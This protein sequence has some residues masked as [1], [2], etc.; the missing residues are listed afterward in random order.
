MIQEAIEGDHYQSI[1]TNGE[2]LFKDKGS[3]FFAFARCVKSLDEFQSFLEDLKSQYHDARHFCYAYRFQPKK[4]EVRINDDGEPAHSAG[5]PIFNAI[6]SAEL[7][8]IAV[9][10]VRYF[11]GT[12]LGVPGLINAYRESAVEALQNCQR[13]D[14]YLYRYHELR[15]PYSAMAEVMN[16][17]H[18]SLF[19]IISETMDKDA[20]YIIRCRESKLNIALEQIKNL[21]QGELKEIDP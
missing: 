6:L 5:T 17:L 1:S 4:P 7:W 10:V 11:G 21:Y 14:I 13:I 3:K 2:A 15:F 12:K 20:G 19:E 16:I 18:Q 8:D 9:V